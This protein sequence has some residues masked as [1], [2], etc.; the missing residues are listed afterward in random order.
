MRSTWWAT[1]RR[2]RRRSSFAL[3]HARCTANRAFCRLRCACYASRARLPAVP[4]RSS[5][6]P[7]SLMVDSSCIRRELGWRPVR[8]W[9]QGMAEWWTHTWRRTVKSHHECSRADLDRL[10]R[11]IVDNEVNVPPVLVAAPLESVGGCAS[12][13]ALGIRVTLL[14]ADGAHRPGLDQAPAGNAMTIIRLTGSLR[15]LQRTRA[16]WPRATHNDRL[17]E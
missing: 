11:V 15:P 5:G 10:C 6:S 2:S 4:R 17:I 7:F 16:G 9:E 14:R 12:A 13:H 8:S 1:T 3:L